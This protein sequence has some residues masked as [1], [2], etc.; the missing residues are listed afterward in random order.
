[1]Q[2][3]NPRISWYLGESETTA[4]QFYMRSPSF[5]EADDISM[6]RRSTDSAIGRRWFCA[7]F[8]C[9]PPLPVRSS[10]ISLILKQSQRSCE[11]TKGRHMLKSRLYF[12][13]I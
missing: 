3:A 4:W 10:R 1:M 13:Q 2:N 8:F 6:A 12:D 5:S 7:T 11:V 9:L